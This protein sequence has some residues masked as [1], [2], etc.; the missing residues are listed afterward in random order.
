MLC[1]SYPIWRCKCGSW[2]RVSWFP[3]ARPS[4][5]CQTQ[6]SVLLE[7][8][9]AHGGTHSC[10]AAPRK[11]HRMMWQQ[12]VMSAVCYDS[13]IEETQVR[14]LAFFSDVGVISHCRAVLTMTVTIVCE[15]RVCIVCMFLIAVNVVIT[16]SSAYLII[17]SATAMWEDVDAPPHVDRPLRWNPPIHPGRHVG[18][19]MRTREHAHYLQPS[20]PAIRQCGWCVLFP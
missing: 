15:N 18:T 6:G 14:Q 7:H 10:P 16:N 5:A 9:L 8:A 20:V 13:I 19:E 11:K 17:I 12:P 4:K 2:Q 3:P 1:T